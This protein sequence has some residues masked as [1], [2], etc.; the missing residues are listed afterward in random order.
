MLAITLN[1]LINIYI[2]IHVFAL[3]LCKLNKKNPKIKILLPAELQPHPEAVQRVKQ[4]EYPHD[5]HDGCMGFSSDH[6]NAPHYHTYDIGDDPQCPLL[7][8]SKC[9]K[10]LGNDA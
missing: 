8:K 9:H 2:L 7:H 5:Y 4:I 3:K 1:F 6:A 10:G